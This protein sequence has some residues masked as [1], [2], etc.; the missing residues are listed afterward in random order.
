VPATTA[1]LPQRAA[2]RSPREPLARDLAH[3]RP[4]ATVSAMTHRSILLFVVLLFPARPGFAQTKPPA[5]T[6]AAATFDRLPDVATPGTKVVVTDS[7]GN[8][9]VGKIGSITAD[10]LLLK[11]WGNKTYLLKRDEIQNIRKPGDTSPNGAVV[12]ALAGLG[13]AVGLIFCCVDEDANGS[14]LLALVP[15]LGVA[16]YFADRASQ[17]RRLLYAKASGP[18]VSFQHALAGN[19]SVRADAGLVSPSNRKPAPRLAANIVI[20][21]GS[22]RRN[23]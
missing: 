20:S 1:L 12:G 2:P 7:K 23:P 6:P 16:G 8:A 17:D 18:K 4:E 22:H 19:I 21:L 9:V 11:G 13:A 5:E 15:G 14:W 10:A 3:Y